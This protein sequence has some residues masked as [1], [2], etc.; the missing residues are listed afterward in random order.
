MQKSM[1]THSIGKLITK[2]R[3][4]RGL[5]LRELAGQ[6]ETSHQTITAFEAGEG[7]NLEV[8]ARIALAL[9]LRITVEPYE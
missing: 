2:T 6:A 8:L 7:R 9:D 1:G 4:A 3:E 5:S